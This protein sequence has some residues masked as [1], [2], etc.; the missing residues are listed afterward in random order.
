MLEL[1]GYLGW[2][3]LRLGLLPRGRTVRVWYL[4]R[5]FCF[6][7]EVMYVIGR[8]RGISTCTCNPI[9]PQITPAELVGARPPHA[10]VGFDALL[11]LALDAEAA[12][13][14]RK[15]SLFDDDRGEEREKERQRRLEEGLK[16]LSGQLRV[17]PRRLLVVTGEAPLVRAGRAGGFFTCLVQG[18]EKEGEGGEGG[19]GA[20]VDYRV[21]AWE[22][23]R[24][25][26]EDLNGV[27]LRPWPP[28]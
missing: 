14:E 18:E 16:W 19:R 11:P 2:R 23:V 12:E 8:N 17:E 20:G 4:I 1:L 3:G 21:G 28:R 27:S 9:Q 10:S 6:V 25:V 5:V 15:L 22:E 13:R 26:V 24:D 7:V